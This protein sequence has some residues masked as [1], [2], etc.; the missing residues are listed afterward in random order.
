MLRLQVGDD[1]LLLVGSSNFDQRFNNGRLFSF[2]LP[3]L[4]ELVPRDQ[5]EV[6]FTDSF[7]PAILDSVRVDSFS[8][9]LATIE[10]DPGGAGARPYVLSPSRKRNELTVVRVEDG[11]ILRCGESTP[12]DPRE[13][14]FDC[15][16]THRIKLRGRDTFSV[17]VTEFGDQEL[18]AVGSLTSD[19]PVP[20]IFE[21]TFSM[22]S[23]DYIE[24]RIIGDVPVLPP[25]EDCNIN[26]LAI[27][28]IRGVTDFVPSSTTT[29]E[30]AAIISLSFISSPNLSLVEHVV[31]FVDTDPETDEPFDLDP[32]QVDQPSDCSVDPRS[33]TLQSEVDELVR[34]DVSLGAFEARGVVMSGDGRRA[35]VTV[36]FPPD[37]VE[38]TNSAVVVVD[39]IE[40]P[41]RILNLLEIGEELGA[42]N[43]DEGRPDGTR[44]LY[45]GDQRFDYV[46]VVNVSGD[47]PQFM[48]RI[49]SRGLRDFGGGEIR[50]VRLLDQPTQIVF[51]QDGDRRLAFVSNFANSTMGVIDV[52]DSNP[53]R[54]HVIARL[55]RDLDPLGEREEP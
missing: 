48:A 21:T 1:D 2:S 31:S 18:V 35:Y 4:F 6:F 5:S 49:E 37:I 39:M 17:G 15:T 50:Q 29:P 55:G 10:L 26:N 42:P 38:A 41:P 23:T 43:L 53:R 46:Y 45:V 22:L 28:G 54:H 51:A 9:Q 36:R 24:A 30:S 47:Q 13:I 40:S 7:G 16:S 12:E 44:L 20:G 8:G 19:S 34:F 14:G 32:E 27:G 33:E 52:T 11:G 3:A 25:D